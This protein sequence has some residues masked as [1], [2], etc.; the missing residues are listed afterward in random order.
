MIYADVL[1]KALF[2]E[3]LELRNAIIY[4]CPGGIKA[5]WPES[6]VVF[7]TNI[8]GERYLVPGKSEYL[9]IAWGGSYCCDEL[10][11]TLSRGQVQLD[12]FNEHTEDHKQHQWLIGEY[13]ALQR[14]IRKKA[15]RIPYGTAFVYVF[16]DAMKRLE[17]KNVQIV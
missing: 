14:W 17:G 8:Y 3:Y 16:P 1:D 10:S 12:A 9:H 4:P 6:R 11:V 2:Q 13:K 5:V 15:K 7:G